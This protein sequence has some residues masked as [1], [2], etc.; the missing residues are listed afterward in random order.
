MALALKMI[1]EPELNT[2][3]MYLTPE[4]KEGLNNI[5]AGILCS[6]VKKNALS[7]FYR[8]YFELQESFPAQ[9]LAAELAGSGQE[10]WFQS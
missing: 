9:E 4:W 2:I 1:C 3:V 10:I 8:N 5:V 7:P 6:L